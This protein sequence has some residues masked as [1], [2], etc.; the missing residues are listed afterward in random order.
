M[1]PQEKAH[2]FGLYVLV[3]G[4]LHQG[5]PV[6]SHSERSGHWLC[7]ATIPQGPV[8]LV[9][10]NQGGVTRG[11]Q[12]LSKH[13]SFSDTTAEVLSSVIYLL[14]QDAGGGNSPHEATVPGGKAPWLTFQG[15]TL[16]PLPEL[17]CVVAE[18]PPP[19]SLRLA[20]SALTREEAEREIAACA[21]VYRLSW[22]RVNRKPCWRHGC[23]PDRWLAFT[24]AGWV[25]Q[26]RSAL[27]QER[28]WVCLNDA[29]AEMPCN[30]T[31][32]WQVHRGK[33]WV[34]DP[35][36][37]CR[38][39]TQYPSANEATLFDDDS[40]PSLKYLDD[41]PDHYFQRWSRPGRGEDL[42]DHLPVCLFGHIGAQDVR[43]GLLGDC[44]LLSGMSALADH[45]QLVR[46]LF[47][48][49]QI[50]EAGR[51]DV[52]LFHPK[53][54]K[55]VTI[56]V[57][58]SLPI[59]PDGELLF[60][61]LNSEG[62]IW[63]CL[64]EKAVAELLGG[65][66]QLCGC[67]PLMGFKVLAGCRDNKL[68]QLS[69]LGN[70]QWQ[71]STFKVLKLDPGPNGLVHDLEWS[72]VDWPAASEATAQATPSTVSAAK[73]Y[74]GHRPAAEAFKLLAS[75]DLTRNHGGREVSLVEKAADGKGAVLMA[76][77]LSVSQHFH[78][79][80]GEEMME[81]QMQAAI[82]SR[83]AEG[84]RWAHAYTVLNVCTD[85]YGSGVNLIK[86]RNTHASEGMVW[87]GAWSKDWAGWAQYPQLRDRLGLDQ[88]VQEWTDDGGV[89]WMC[90]EDFL[91][92]CGDIFLGLT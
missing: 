53:T 35:D 23:N 54:D 47:A 56:T 72:Y 12:V 55:W 76:C 9:H 63:P 86:I 8:W 40:P 57:D 5:K 18:A 4:A 70:G 73:S 69:N 39:S 91:A 92:R 58:D 27:G 32:G 81:E 51:Y 62:E 25:V 83:K 36:I 78:A 26:S 75:L 44:W 43:Q 1:L 22:K 3:E 31:A 14:I 16:T 87:N 37:E 77:S 11:P 71:C 6:W 82:N 60:S 48:Q 84:L 24:G 33:G 50:D 74:S 68:L 19:P 66:K 2:C 21:G 88:Q 45:R 17:T 67:S 7:H 89:F 42:R 46:N 29:G 28:G 41:L 52:R 85:L 90:E 64:V 10:R 34:R 38:T 20:G 59:G 61:R 80:D 13:T 79:G 65:Y 30:S 15:G 49:K